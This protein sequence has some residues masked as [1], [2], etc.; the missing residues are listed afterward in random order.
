MIKI[1]ENIFNEFEIEEP[2]KIITFKELELD[3]DAINRV[4]RILGEHYDYHSENKEQIIAD[5]IMVSINTLEERQKMSFLAIKEIVEFYLNRP[6][7]NNVF[8]LH[9]NLIED[10]LKKEFPNGRY[11]ILVTNLNRDLLSI[12]EDI[13]IISS[14]NFEFGEY[15]KRLFNYN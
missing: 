12:K 6:H 8:H 11:D 13:E 14:F 7:V 1:L 10:T 3:I 2:E 5:S 4:I 9:F 15:R